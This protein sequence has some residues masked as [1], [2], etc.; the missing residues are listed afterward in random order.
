M[1]GSVPEIPGI[2]AEPELA[3][4]FRREV[5]NLLGRKNL[6]FPGAQP[7]SF[8]RRHIAELQSEE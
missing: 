3:H 2:K 7:V 8:A 4:Q 1:A 6:G 5:A